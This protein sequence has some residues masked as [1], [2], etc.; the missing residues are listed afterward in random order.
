MKRSSPL[1]QVHH[2]RSGP[3]LMPVRGPMPLL[4]EVRIRQ[5]EPCVGPDPFLKKGFQSIGIVG[6]LNPR[7][8]SKYLS[9]RDEGVNTLR[10]LM[11]QR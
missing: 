1:I 7:S 11:Q 6:Q 3:L 4:L 2:G 10:I 5:N 8:I 9:V